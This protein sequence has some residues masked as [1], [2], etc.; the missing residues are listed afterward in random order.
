M[1]RLL[2][3][4][5]L[6]LLLTACGSSSVSYDVQT[7]TDDA[8]VQSAL[9][10][11]SL[12]VVERRM[13]SL[14]E[15][16]LDLNMEQNG[17]GNTLYVEAQEQAALDILSDLLSAPFDLQVMK[18]ATVE[19]ADQVVEGH[20]GFKQVGINQ[21][22]IMWLSASEEPGGKGRVTITFSEEGRGK[23]GKLFKENKGK[24][25]GIFVRS[26]LVSKLLVETDELKDDIVIT[27]IP[28]VQLAHVFADDVNVGIHMTFR[29]LP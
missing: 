27:D 4:F 19:E 6:L 12:R 28:T 1:K 20:G 24:F 23:M 14:G 16:V 10:A 26:Q 18:Q 8:E 11:A 22:D 25:I 29:P 13:A 5:A 21:D 15:P 17:E 9:L 7:N 2:S 3:S